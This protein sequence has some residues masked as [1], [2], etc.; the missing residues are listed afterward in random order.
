[1]KKIYN[2]VAMTFMAA[3]VLVGC[4]K[5]DPFP[6]SPSDS[7]EGQVSMK[8]M[9]VEV[10][11]EEEIVR[12]SIDVSQFIVTISNATGVVG[13]Y[14]YKDMPEVLTLPVGDYTVDVKSHA[15]KAAAW[16]EPYFIGSQDFTIEADK[17]TEVE[18]VVCKLSNV[19]VTVEYDSK[20]L[21]VMGDDCK[22]NVK[23]GEAGVL[24]FVKAET[25][26][27]YFKYDEGSSTMV[28]TFTG[29]VQGVM[30]ENFRTY[31][32]VAPGK[33]YIIT[34]TLR[35]PGGEVPDVAGDVATGVNVSSYVTTENL[36]LDAGEE[37]EIL[38]DDER[39]IEDP[40]VDPED[41]GNPGGSDDPVTPAA[42]PTVEA[43]APITFDAP[44]VVTAASE[45]TINVQSN[46]ED[47]ITEF[48]VEIDSEAISE[49]LNAQLGTSTLDF[50]NP[51]SDA[52]ANFINELGL[53][54]GDVAGR[55]DL[56]EIKITGFMGML[57][58]LG[59][60][61]HNFIIT[62]GDDNGTTTKTLTLVIE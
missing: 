21:A 28:A 35:T 30:E 7:G 26:S 43:V 37:D 54:E 59:A 32:D 5:E 25:R 46:H 12:S 4:S 33:H 48:K 41:P 40:I 23:V 17:I 2:I 1:M 16:E 18:T 56:I 27:G 22:V 36:T 38:E 53:V 52:V 39:P 11:N 42:G 19:R 51:A 31:V 62:V 60:G 49:L 55:T 10:T 47:G 57:T 14:A 20:L 24:D 61:S 3:I 6:T 34:Y 58:A 8:K 29:S 44:N 50:I 15:V 13:E 45:V 9:L